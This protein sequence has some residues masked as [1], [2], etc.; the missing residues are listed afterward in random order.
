M[1]KQDR[2]I[3]YLTATGILAAMITLMTAYVCH[4]P[5]GSSGGYLHFGD[6]L[7]YLGAVL[8][9]KPYAIAAAVIGGGLADLLTAP[10]WAPAT[11]IIKMLLVV[12]FDHRSGKL[13]NVRNIAALVIGGVIT[14]FGYF[15]AE[16]LMFGAWAAFFTSV[17]PNMIQAAGSALFFI[18]MAGALQKI[19]FKEKMFHEIKMENDK[20]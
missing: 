2:K 8:L 13:L 4:I 19:N 7:I 10:L 1:T 5:F 18:L 3:Q 17:F 11:M 14:C 16:Y 12:S 20:R 9:P 6:A 15:L